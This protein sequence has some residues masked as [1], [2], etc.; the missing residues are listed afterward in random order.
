MQNQTLLAE[1][2][3]TFVGFEGVPCTYLRSLDEQTMHWKPLCFNCH[4]LV[5]NHN[6][7][8]Q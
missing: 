1:A 6:C 4:I 5:L 7:D 3:T 8:F 2:T